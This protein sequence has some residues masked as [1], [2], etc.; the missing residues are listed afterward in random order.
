MREKKLCS[1]TYILAHSAKLTDVSTAG[2]IPHPT[3]QPEI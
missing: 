3:S 2:L 1:K